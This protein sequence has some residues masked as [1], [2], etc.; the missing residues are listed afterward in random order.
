M[1]RNTA[2][3]QIRPLHPKRAEFWRAICTRIG[4]HKA[5]GFKACSRRKGCATRDVLCYQAIRRELNALILPAL[6]ARRD[7]R[8]MP[9]WP[10]TQAEWDAALAD[11]DTWPQSS[12]PTPEA[13]PPQPI[14]PEAGVAYRQGGGDK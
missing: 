9:K 6:Q 12:D 10:E 3:I 1:K 2:D 14:D 13:P 11:D 4:L 7:G 8:P 5:C